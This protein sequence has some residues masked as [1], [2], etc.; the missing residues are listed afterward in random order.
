MSDAT[1]AVQELIRPSLK[2]WLLVALN[3]AVKPEAEIV[4]HLAEHLKYMAEQEDK[5]F[6]SGPFF[7]EGRLTGEGLIIFNLTERRMPWGSCP[8]SH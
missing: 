3:Y 2:K 6:L 8:T 4:P 7:K 1:A 5:V